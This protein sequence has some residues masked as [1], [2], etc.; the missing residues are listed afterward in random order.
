MVEIIIQCIVTLL[1]GLIA[2]IQLGRD[3]RKK[4]SKINREA[5]L[6]LAFIIVTAVCATGLQIKTYFDNQNSQVNLQSKFHG[7]QSKIDGLSIKNDSLSKQNE[8]YKKEVI[9]EVDSR[10]QTVVLQ[11]SKRI[12]REP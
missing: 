6:S 12:D 9:N 11:A 3:F 1:T 4:D 5:K 10:S 2:G 8:K 7:L